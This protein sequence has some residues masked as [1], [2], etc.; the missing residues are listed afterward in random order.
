MPA[1]T[2][3]TQTAASQTYSHL[4]ERAVRTIAAA[5][6]LDPDCPVVRGNA[7]QADQFHGQPCIHV[8]TGKLTVSW[9]TDHRGYYD[10]AKLLDG[11]LSEE[12]RVARCDALAHRDFCRNAYGE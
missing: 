1:M 10:A 12:T 3:Q 6:D 8:A 11:Y 7:S 4:T 2:S 9:G 5:Y